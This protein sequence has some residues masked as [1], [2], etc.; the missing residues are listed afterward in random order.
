M[1]YIL[2]KTCDVY[3]AFISCHWSECALAYRCSNQAIWTSDERRLIFQKVL[4]RQN[5]LDYS[6]CNS[7]GLIFS[8]IK[9]S[10]RPHTI[11]R[12]ELSEQHLCGAW[13]IIRK[14]AGPQEEF[15]MHNKKTL[16]GNQWQPLSTTKALRPD[17]VL[18]LSSVGI[19]EDTWWAVGEYKQ[20]G[21]E[22]QWLQALQ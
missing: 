19:N 3:F 16:G 2:W 14:S 18:T 10:H 9:C 12:A 13:S 11:F 20:C 21:I 5:Q 8:D 1:Q 17:C 22:W 15:C 6:Q 4:Y 7:T